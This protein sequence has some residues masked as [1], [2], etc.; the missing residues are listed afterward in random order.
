MF[1]VQKARLNLT[2]FAEGKVQ[3]VNNLQA[4]FLECLKNLNLFLECDEYKAQAKEVGF[5]V[6]GGE[7]AKLDEFPHMSAIGIRANNDITWQCGGSLISEDYIV[8]AAH[9]AKPNIR[10]DNLVV[11]IGDLNL[12]RDDDGATPQEFGVKRIVVHPDYKNGIRYH[13]L[14]LMQL[15]RKAV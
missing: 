4:S 15:N 11:R 14:A 12:K 1:A 10:M 9:C 5:G 2:K 3:S 8:T 7:K 6:V 13:D